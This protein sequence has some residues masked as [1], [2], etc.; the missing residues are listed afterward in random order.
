MCKQSGDR[1]V[2]LLTFATSAAECRKS[3][4]DG[5]HLVTPCSNSADAV[6]TRKGLDCYY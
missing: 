5:H 6:C 1:I 3:C 2:C 4:P